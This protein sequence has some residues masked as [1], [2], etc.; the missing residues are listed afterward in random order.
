MSRCFPFPPPG[1]EKKITTV[2]ADPLIK[3]KQKKEKKHKKE[4]KDKEKR[5]GKE[6]KDKETSKD[7]HKDRKE[8]NDKP[9]DRKDKDRDRE[10][11]RAAEEEKAV[12][13]LPDTGD[14]KFVQDLARRINSEEEARESQSAK[15]SEDEV[16]R[17]PSCTVQK[18]AEVMFKPV[19][20]KDKNE[21]QEKNHREETVRKSDKQLHNEEMKKSE[22][23]TT[24]D[25][26]SKEIN[27]TG[28][29]KPKYVEGGPRLKEREGILGKRKDHEAANGLLYENGSNP[30]IPN[31]VHRPGAS[32]LSSVENGRK[33]GAYQTPPK[34][35]SELQGTVCNS[36]VKKHKI[37]GFIE[38]Q[39]SKSRPPVS[40]VKVKENGVAS[41]KK[42]PHSDLKYLDQI[43]NVPKRE[44]LLEVDDDEKEW[45][46][47]QSGVKLSKK[48]RADSSSSVSLDE[49]LQVWNKALRLE[50]ADI[51]AL[52]YVVP[53]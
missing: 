51:I 33:L 41:A 14:D 37:N 48:Q 53:F 21:L 19:E 20:R 18:E 25:T 8:K 7:K 32:P 24:R 30:K 12:V 46:F 16:L 22:P 52:P 1:Y 3:E 10:K 26:S 43:L 9:K 44:E 36:E 50:S 34:S 28:Q 11:R 27:K 5:E 2:E 38:S 17:V 29:E 42:R 49:A 45:L 40:S 35:V 23:K 39:E 47:G 13:P 4:K 6:K 31:K 15:R